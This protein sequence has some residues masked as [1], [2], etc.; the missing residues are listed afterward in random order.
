MFKYYLKIA[1]RNILKYKMQ[2]FTGILGLAFALA[3]IVPTLYWINYETSYDHFYPDSKYIYRIYTIEK[4]SGKMN[5]GSSRIVED[6]LH[7]YFPSIESSTTFLTGQENCQTDIIP[8]IR[9][10]M[11]YADSTFFNIFPQSIICSYSKDPLQTINDMVLTESVAKRLFGDVEKAIGQKVQTTMNSALPPYM[12]T[13]VVKDPFPNSNISFDAIIYHDMLKS[14]SQWPEEQQWVT[15]FVDL[16][17]KLDPRANV[18]EVAENLCNFASRLGMN[19]DIELRMMPIKDIRHNLHKDVPFT[20]NFIELFLSFGILLLSSALFNFL[21]LNIDLFRQRIHEFH[22][23]IVN[24]ALRIQIIG[25]MIFELLFIVSL[26]LLSAFFLVIAFSFELSILLDID[27]NMSKLFSIFVIFVFVI[28]VFI[29][30]IAFILFWKLS[31]IAMRPK[32]DIYIYENPILKRVAL[33]LQLIVSIVFIIAALVVMLQMRYVSHK[34]L[35]FDCHG[36]IQLTGFTDFSGKIQNTLIQELS[37]ISLVESITDTNFQPKHSIDPNAII[38]K[39]EWPGKSFNEKPT[40]DLILTD[41]RFAETFGLKIV[42]GKWW[43][44][45]QMKKMILNEE[46]VRV[47]KLTNPVGSIIRMPSPDDDSLVDYEVMGVVNDFHTLSLRNHIYPTLFIPSFYPNNNLYIRVKPSQ[48]Y[49]LIQLITTLLPSINGC[50][51]N[52]QITSVNELY[53]RLSFSEKVGLILFSVLAIVSILISMFGIYAVVS[54]ATYRRRKEIAIRKVVG[55]TVFDIIC[56]FLM[57]YIYVVFIAGAIALP[58]AYFAMDY[59]LQGYAYRI[60]IQGWLL[61]STLIGVFIVV[62]ITI[63]GQVLKAASSNPAEVIKN[64]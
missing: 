9:L 63:L 61:L 21:N 27:I 15:Y 62:I 42:D 46:A 7:E 17:V 39:L 47:M 52:A 13:A 29:L 44:K 45:G 1:Y 49:E 8:Y 19:H 6:K 32:S 43:N 10:E 54:T 41:Y 33:I 28:V 12:V 5:N 35:G 30:I 59:W 24:G 22:L 18:D 2:S 34:D 57:E 20:L 14:L 40:F 53:D 50:L 31:C 38:T 4:Q 58:F 23:R 16:Y 64:E 26:S 60:N 48:E 36:L 25:Q 3:C 56:I 51:T 11:L 37:N 55:S